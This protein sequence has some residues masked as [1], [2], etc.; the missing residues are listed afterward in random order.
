MSFPTF[1]K[2]LLEARRPRPAK[3][4]AIDTFIKSV[5][6]L[7][8]DVEKL[9]KYQKA[10]EKKKKDVE[11]LSKYQK[12]SGT[13]KKEKFYEINRTSLPIQTQNQNQHLLKTG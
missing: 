9:S 10:S 2:W 5:E 1:S 6:E 8:K 12:A 11:K 4:T 13:K 3:N 7:Q